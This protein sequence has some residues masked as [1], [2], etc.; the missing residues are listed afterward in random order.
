MEDKTLDT[1]CSEATILL[2]LH[3]KLS[4]PIYIHPTPSEL[5]KIRQTLASEYG[6]IKK[7][8]VVLRNQYRCFLSENSIWKVRVH[9][10]DI[11][12]YMEPP[13]LVPSLI[14]AMARSTRVSSVI[15]ELRKRGLPPNPYSS[16]SGSC[17]GFYVDSFEKLEQ[18][19]DDLGSAGLI[20]DAMIVN[21]VWYMKLNRLINLSKLIE[22]GIFAHT[23]SKFKCVTGTIEDSKVTVFNTGTVR[24]L[25]APKPDYAKE[26]AGKVYYILNKYNAI[27]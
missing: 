19:V 10:I 21:V 20:T 12:G 15:E 6:G 26:I 4:V 27:L 2:P 23:A 11:A 22:T 25:R 9:K 1:C 14:L 5:M 24:I 3:K 7:A 17:V 13:P 18:V 16:L 8:K